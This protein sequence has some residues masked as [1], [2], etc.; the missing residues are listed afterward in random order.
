MILCFKPA[1][2]RKISNINEIYFIERVDEKLI[3]QRKSFI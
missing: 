3:E 2:N 1:H